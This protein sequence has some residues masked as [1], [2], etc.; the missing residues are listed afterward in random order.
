MLEKRQEALRTMKQALAL[1]PNDP[2]LLYNVAQTYNKLGRINQALEWL[3]KALAA[4]INPN[5]V[6]DNP[7]LDNLRTD[8]RYF[9]MVQP[10]LP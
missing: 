2:E 3:E 6:R 7:F 1:G 9:T 4:G 5:T 10:H 8:P